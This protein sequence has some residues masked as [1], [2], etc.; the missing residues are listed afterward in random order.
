MLLSRQPHHDGSALCVPDQRP[1]L[2]DAVDVLARTHRDDPVEAVAVRSVI[3][4]EPRFAAARV[5]RTEGPWTWWRATVRAANPRTTYRFLLTA[6]GDYRWLNAAGVHRRDVTDAGDFKLLAGHHP[7]EWIPDAIAYQIFP[8]RFA[9][10]VDG[11]MAPEWAIPQEWDDPVVGSGP[12]TPL[13]W[14]GGDLPGIEAHLD[15]LRRL[16][17]SVLYLTPIFPGR[18]N[19]RYNAETFDR[20]D[21]VLG[22][23]EALISLIRA[24]HARGIRVVGDLTSNHTGSTHEWFRRAQADAGSVEAGFYLFEEHPQ[25]YVQWIDEPLLPKL[26]WASAELRRRFA[27]GPASV[28]ARWLAGPDGFDGWRIDVANMTG[29]YADV[30]LTHDVARLIRRTTSST[31]AEAWL[32]AEHMHDPAHD[33]QLPD[34]WHGTMNYA[35]FTRPVWAWLNSPEQRMEWYFGQPPRAPRLPGEA[36]LATMREVGSQLPWRA[37]V[38]SM[39]CLDSHDTPRFRT[40]AGGREAGRE[41]HLVAAA[42]L[43]TM[44]GV[45]S[46]F[47]GQELGLE[48]VNGEDSRRPMP[49]HR[50]ESWDTATLAAYEIYSRVRADS[51]ALRRGGLRWLAIS[52]DALTFL[53]E[54]SEERVLVHA[55]RAGHPRVRLELADLGGGMPQTLFGADAK[56]DGGTVELPDAGPAAHAYLLA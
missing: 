54:T 12:R 10:G 33:L 29:R 34:G 46:V 49:W 25:R 35:G 50:P 36:V 41:R 22:G 27:D 1:D 19:H 16:H 15:H 47:A 48:G 7:P 45:P 42:L 52:D 2:G 55:A 38:H 43:F 18:S 11:R 39:N 28:V 56:V 24:A 17:S 23:D 5:D 51:L 8:D 21:P 20:I 14:Y 44:P 9:R 3:D 26:N 40:L 53:R 30:E 31:D 6:A 37:L 13:Q 32:V 4:G